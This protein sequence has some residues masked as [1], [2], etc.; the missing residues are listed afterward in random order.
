MGAP[1]RT[2]TVRMY[3]SDHAWIQQRQRE[4]SAKAGKWIDLPELLHGLIVAVQ[5]AEEG[6]L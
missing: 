5:N 2:T 1:E 6:V 3:A 4:I